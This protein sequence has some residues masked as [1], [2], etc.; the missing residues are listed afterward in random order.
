MKMPD[1]P[2]YVVYT[3]SELDMVRSQYFALLRNGKEQ[4]CK[5][6]SSVADL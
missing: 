6:S 1:P 5:M 2:E 3:D 4:D